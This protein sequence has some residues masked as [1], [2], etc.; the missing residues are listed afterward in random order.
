MGICRSLCHSFSFENM[1]FAVDG[2]AFP[3]QILQEDLLHRKFVTECCYFSILLSHMFPWMNK[4]LFKSSFYEKENC[5]SPHFIFRSKYELYLALNMRS[6]K[7][8]NYAI[9]QKIILCSILIGY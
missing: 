7:T 5:S 9:D 6:M 1:R 4:F 8:I 3:Y 2:Y